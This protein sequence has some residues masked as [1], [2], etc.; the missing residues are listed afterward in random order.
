[1]MK[2][3]ILFLT[4]FSAHARHAI[5]YGIEAFPPA[6]FSYVLLHSYPRIHTTADVTISLSE[7]MRKESYEALDKE[8]EAVRALTGQQVAFEKVAYLGF[9][10]EAVNAVADAM[11]PDLVVMGTKG[12]TGLPAILLGSHA[13][14]L[15]KAINLPLLIV[16]EEAVYSVIDD[17][18]LAA[19]AATI[20]KPEH[21]GPLSDIVNTFNSRLIVINVVQDQHTPGEE[22]SDDG[23]ALRARF[24]DHLISFRTIHDTVI[25]H[26]IARFVEDHPTD[27]LVVVERSRS[28]IVDL[29][30]RSVSKQL[31]LHTKTPLLILHG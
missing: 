4:D 21:L 31:A 27:L 29:F 9:L 14:S 13:S 10:N 2:N 16:P 17:I 19:D 23:K 15:I 28:F 3:K 26:G 30:H 24:G 1:M 22:E 12:E 18:V 11:E 20:N 8:E 5:R 25:G 7:Q 6:D